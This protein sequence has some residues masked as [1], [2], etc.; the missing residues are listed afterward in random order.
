MIFSASEAAPKTSCKARDVCLAKP[1]R[2]YLF[3]R[4]RRAFLHF[5][6]PF[7][8]L[9]LPLIR[10]EL[11]RSHKMARVLQSLLSRVAWEGLGE[12]SASGPPH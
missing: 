2:I 4:A 9:P 1:Y 12:G 5:G 3:A 10:R 7:V 11:M 6:S 8:H